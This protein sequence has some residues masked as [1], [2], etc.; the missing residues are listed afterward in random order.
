MALISISA[1]EVFERAKEFNILPSAIENLYS[2]SEDNL[3]TEIALGR[4]L[5][6]LKMKLSFSAFSEGK[7][8]FKIK[9]P[10]VLKLPSKLVKNSFMRIL[11]LLKRVI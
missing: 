6:N 7:A 1:D 2:D 9:S 4:L 3:I 11:S 5:P 8:I 10:V